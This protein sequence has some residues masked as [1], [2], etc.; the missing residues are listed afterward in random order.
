VDLIGPGARAADEEGGAALKNLKLEPWEVH[1]ALRVVRR[2]DELTGPIQPNERLFFNA[3]ALRLRMDE[4]AQKLRIL[5]E[6]RGEQSASD[7]TLA[8]SANCLVRAREIDAHFRR[9]L[10]SAAD[11]PATAQKE[12]TRSRFRH[13]RAFAGLWLLF[14]GLG[15]G[16]T[17]PRR[18]MV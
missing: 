18:Q 8:P 7:E 14:N 9:A 2:R 6:D 12:L 4:E 10:R 3:A 11:R 17:E 5:V 13:L 16:E 15:G 1:A